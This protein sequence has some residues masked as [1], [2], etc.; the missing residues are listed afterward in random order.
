MRNCKL[1]ILTSNPFPTEAIRCIVTS[2]PNLFHRV[3]VRKNEECVKNMTLNKCQFSL[4]C[5]PLT[6]MESLK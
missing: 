5:V 6:C 3:I 2:V 4:F 1:E